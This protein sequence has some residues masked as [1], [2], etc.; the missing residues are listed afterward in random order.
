MKT[1]KDVGLGLLYVILWTLLFCY[2]SHAEIAPK[3]AQEIQRALRRQGYAISL[4][5]VMDGPTTSA[6]R[7][8]AKKNGWQTK[9][10]PDARVLQRIGL[11][12]KPNKLLN[13]DTAAFN[14]LA[15]PRLKH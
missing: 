9:C 4:S 11:G 15:L 13:P 3:R 8:V 14:L 12:A 10:V 2:A 1:K 6:L 5:G 7:D